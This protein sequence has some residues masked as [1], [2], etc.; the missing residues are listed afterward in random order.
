MQRAAPGQIDCMLDILPPSA[1]ARATRAAAMT[2]REF[3]R[4]VLM[5][6]VG[7]LGGEDLGLPYPWIMRNSITIRGRW[8]YPREA[9]TR[10]VGL[11]RSG[12]LDLGNFRDQRVQPLRGERSRCECRP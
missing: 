11:V 8:L 6:G 12:Q 3:G 9:F 1:P 2:V 5:G 10:M 4:V 7:M